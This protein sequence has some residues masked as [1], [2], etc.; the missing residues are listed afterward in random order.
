[1]PKLNVKE[2]EKLRNEAQK[3]V[4]DIGTA[5]IIVHMGTCG[6]ASGAQEVLDSLKSEIK[7]KKINDISVKTTGCAG[8][9]SREPM[10]T[11]EL[12]GNQPVKYADL[13]GEKM[14][15]ILEEHVLGSNIVKKYALAVGKEQIL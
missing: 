2:L 11:V 12:P 13:N 14:K 7:S 9:C 15:T 3:K 1:M 6:I 5:R 8:L 4:A 10:V